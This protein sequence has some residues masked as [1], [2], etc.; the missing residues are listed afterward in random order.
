MAKRVSPDEKVFNPVEEALVRSALGSVD[1][2]IEMPTGS[3]TL[4]NTRTDVSEEEAGQSPPAPVPPNVVSIETGRKA[5]PPSGSAGLVKEV[6]K[7]CRVKR[8][9]LTDSEDD[10]LEQLVSDVGRR[11]G[12]P[13]TLSHL[14]RATATLL[15]H[16]RDEILKQSGKMGGLK[17]PSNN[18]PVAIASFEHNITRLIDRA[19]R[20]SRVPD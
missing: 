5:Q 13:L 7:L 20:N 17:R 18:D 8:F 16:S 12:T 14:L 6:E 1:A 2:E 15:M 19:I 9:L 3:T 4:A 11:L 10:I